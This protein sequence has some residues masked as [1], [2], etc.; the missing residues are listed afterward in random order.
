MKEEQNEKLGKPVIT[1]KPVFAVLNKVT[2]TL[3][4]NENVKNMYRSYDMK[5]LK[6][7]NS[8]LAWEGTHC[9]Q[10]LRGN[11]NVKLGDKT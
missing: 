9:W 3:F 8:P 6:P 2:L 5:F 1:I 7:L 11:K 4:E 10:I